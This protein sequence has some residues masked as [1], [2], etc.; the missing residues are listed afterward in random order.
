MKRIN[1]LIINLQRI[2]SDQFIA[3]DNNKY[4][5]EEA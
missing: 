1:K 3:V 4:S 5:G 2:L